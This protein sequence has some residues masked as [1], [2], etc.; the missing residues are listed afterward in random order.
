MN[1]RKGRREKVFLEQA[2]DDINKK[3]EVLDKGSNIVL[4]GAGENAVRLFQYTGLLAF[5]QLYIVDK[6]LFGKTFFGKIVK[7]PE[8]ILW[9]SM[10]AVIIS[11]F[12]GADEIRMELAEKYDFKGRV[13]SIHENLRVPFYSLGKK[14]DSILDDNMISILQKNS[15]YKNIHEGERVFILC[16]GPSISEMELTRLK[17]EKTIAVSG[18]YLHKDCQTI[19]PD[20]Y[21]LPTFENFLNFDS[22]TEYLRKIQEATLKSQYFFSFHEKQ[23]VDKMREY[24]NR[25]VNYIAF[26]SMPDFEKFDIDL[27]SLAPNPQS[28]SIMALEIAL[29]MGF[30][31]IY[32]IGTE[33][34]CLVTKR[35]THFY[36]YSESIV[37]QGNQY[38][39]AQG[40]LGGPFDLEL[41]STYNLWRQYKKIKQIAERNGAKIYNATKGGILDIFERVEFDTLF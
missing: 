31:T 14:R 40:E 19:S 13:I 2:V 4:W 1:F 29:Y 7:K 41:E 39:N 25:C 5:N 16:T 33:H 27:T 11:A 15:R 3:L 17:N 38:E 8:D 22:A 36:E 18:F 9:D 30:K 23:V 32:L 26:A 12:V 6:R 20:Y 10:D 37:S 24:D 21:C 28:V 35:Y 34:D